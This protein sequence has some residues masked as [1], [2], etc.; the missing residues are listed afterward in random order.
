MAFVSRKKPL[1]LERIAV[2]WADETGETSISAV[3]MPLVSAFARGK[4]RGG[5][6]V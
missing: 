2:L 1:S 5:P 3:V 6:N 4:G